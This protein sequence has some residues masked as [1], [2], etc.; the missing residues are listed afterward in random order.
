[1]KCVLFDLDGVLVNS[2]VLHFETFRDALK[3]VVP[4]FQITWSEHEKEMDGLP[5][6]SKL[7]MLLS[8]GVLTKEESERVYQKKQEL[9]LASLPGTMKPRAT[10][11]QL[12]LSLKSRGLR[13]FCI[14][15]AIRKTVEET[16]KLLEI[17]DFFELVYGNEDATEGKPSPELYLKAIEAAGVE[18]S[19]CLI[20]EDSHHGRQAAYAS[21]A[22]VLEVEDAEDV[23]LELVDRALLQQ[24]IR[25]RYA[26]IKCINIVVPMAGEGSRFKKAGYKDPKPFI[27]VASKPMIRW[28]LDNMLP[29]EPIHVKFNLI[30]R[31]DH[32]NE[33]SLACLFEGM[34]LNVSFEIHVTKDLTEGA[35]CSVLLAKHMIDS[36][37]PLVIVNSDQ[38][39]EWNPD[40]FYKSLLNPTYDG[41]ILTFLQPDPSDIK[42]SYASINNDGLVN[43]VA[44]KKWISPFATVGLYGWA[45]GSDFVRYANQMINKNIRT[46]G[47]FYVCPVYNEA[48][49]EGQKIRVS[50]C[51]GMWGLGV[52][53]D[54]EK[55]RKDYLQEVICQE[56]TRQEVTPIEL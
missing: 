21:G 41:C 5:T 49:S 30:M 12:L 46:N 6:R 13:L 18:A 8:K 16:L 15:N 32:I 43:E 7:R 26:D 29:K 2:R 14:S 48:I 42:W 4:D 50:L 36:E 1:M 10:L 28:V 56:T 34:P 20:L 40:A 52:P 47:E 33:Y 3:E 27:P 53:E 45:R 23:T 54:L 11:T 37:N 55:F 17:F 51:K 24:P 31:A 19:D 9:T 22:H 35:A 25:S 44:E 39:L 38:F